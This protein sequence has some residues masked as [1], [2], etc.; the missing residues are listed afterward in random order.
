M[1]FIAYLR[2][3][4]AYL[5]AGD[6]RLKPFIKKYMYIPVNVRRA[7]LVLWFDVT[8]TTCTSYSNMCTKWFHDK[9]SL[10]CYSVL[11]TIAQVLRKMSLKI[12]AYWFLMPYLSQ[13]FE[14]YQ[15]VKMYTYSVNDLGLKEFLQ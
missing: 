9:S 2:K 12:L 14:S 3:Y 6:P 8:G 15:R 4:A 1:I 7:L 11:S 10:Q 5:G 13:T